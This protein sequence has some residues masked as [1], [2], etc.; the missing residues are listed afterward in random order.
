MGKRQVNHTW[1]VATLHPK[2]SVKLYLAPPY[3]SPV[4]ALERLRE[5]CE[6][7]PSETLAV[8][9]SHTDILDEQALLDEIDRM[10]ENG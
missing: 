8:V 7:Y 2:G 3:D 10:Q 9:F 5:A 4:Q 6:K 1:T